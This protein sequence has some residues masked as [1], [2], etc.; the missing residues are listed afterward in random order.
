M[1]SHYQAAFIVPVG[2]SKIF[3][4]YGWEFESARRLSDSLPEQLANR[5][6]LELSD[7]YTGVRKFIGDMINMSVFLDEHNE[8][9]TLYFQVFGDTLSALE[10]AFSGKDF[11]YE[12]EL[13][14]PGN[15]E[16]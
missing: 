8:I 3:G 14:I 15:V 7:E 1:K 6:K 4:E 12:A 13:F 9:E 11:A 10:N 5:L 16:K 2:A